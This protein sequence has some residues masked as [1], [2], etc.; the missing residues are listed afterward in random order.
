[1]RPPSGRCYRYKPNRHFE[2]ACVNK[3]SLLPFRDKQIYVDLNQEV[4]FS[5]Y[6]NENNIY[7]LAW[8]TLSLIYY[9]NIH[10]ALQNSDFSSRNYTLKYCFY[11]SKVGENWVTK[12][13]QLLL[14]T[15]FDCLF[16]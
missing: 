9:K 2:Y 11:S 6:K 8:H 3:L 5:I 4:I 13:V 16:K 14:E 7:F 10:T 15:I 1:M 12:P